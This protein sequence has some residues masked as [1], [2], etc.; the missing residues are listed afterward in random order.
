MPLDCAKKNQQNRRKTTK[1]TY[2]IVK[3]GDK[4]PRMELAVDAQ[5]LQET[6]GQTV[7]VAEADHTAAAAHST[8]AATTAAAAT[9]AAWRDGTRPLI[10]AAHPLA[11]LVRDYA[12][13]LV[14]IHVE[15]LL[16]HDFSTCQGRTNNDGTYD[17][18]QFKS[19]QR[20]RKNRLSM[21]GRILGI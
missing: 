4:D 5:A 17:T 21:N 3:I 6:G 12:A 13:V 15:I 11:V 8:A 2:I 20:R 14:A 18:V 10:G 7:G 1:T 16:H 9:A 19:A